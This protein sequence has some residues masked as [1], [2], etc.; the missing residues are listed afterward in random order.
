MMLMTQNILYRTLSIVCLLLINFSLSGKDRPNVLM[1]CIDDLRPVLGCYGHKEVLSPN[2]DR[3]ATQSVV[4]NNAF[5]NVPVCGASRASLMTS[6]RPDPTRF[7]NFLSKAEEDV[8]GAKSIAQLFKEAG[9]Y[10]ISNGKVFHHA[11][12]L[13]EESW[14]EPAWIPESDQGTAFNPENKDLIHP[15]MNWGV[16]REAG[17]VPDDVYFD[18]QMTNKTIADLRKLAEKDQPFFLAAGFFKPHLPLNAPDKYFEPYDSET[19]KLSDTTPIKNAPKALAG[20]R[21][22]AFYHM[23]DVEYNSEEFHKLTLEAY[24]ACVT[25]VDTLV[26]RI[27]DELEDLGLADNTIIVVWGDHGWNLGEHNFWGKHNLLRNATRIPFMI[28]A[29]GYEPAYTENLAEMVDLLPTLCELA[30]I[31]T[32]G[33]EKQIHGNSLVKSLKNP[34]GAGEEYVI[35]RFK[36]GDQIITSRYAYAEYRHKDGSIEKMLF[37]HENDPEEDVNV[38]GLPEYASVVEK[39]SAKLEPYIGEISYR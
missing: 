17:R 37:D 3:L 13:D 16:W 30:G 22:I 26:G 23:K 2:F 25:F 34:D 28:K 27:L 8:A 39:L 4:F 10:T 38:A 12:D 1:L 6:V 24:Y 14:S 21:E 31:S 7:I 18:G 19:L 35:V 33:L 32:E 36:I 29:P 9:Y 11:D 15:R 5:C 20:S